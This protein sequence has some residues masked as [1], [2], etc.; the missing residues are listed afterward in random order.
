ML[1]PELTVEVNMVKAAKLLAP[2][3]VI[4]NHV[5]FDL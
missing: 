3:L 5:I 1:P 4:S 2:F